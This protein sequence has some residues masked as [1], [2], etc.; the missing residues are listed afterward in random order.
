MALVTIT[1]DLGNVAS[2]V[3]TT[4]GIATSSV[5]S[6]RSGAAHVVAKSGSA[7]DTETVTFLPGVPTT[8]TVQ[9]G[10][11]TLVVNTSTSTG[12]T[13]TVV[14]FYSNRVPNW[15]LSGYLSPTTL[16]MIGARLT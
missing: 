15:P 11:D 10:T 9:L 7:Q 12:I 1:T 8:T 14:D 6:T 3:T 4:N 13:V 5:S 16:G 2:P